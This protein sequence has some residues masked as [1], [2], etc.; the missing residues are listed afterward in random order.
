MLRSYHQH[1]WILI[2]FYI[3][4]YEKILLRDSGRISL[5]EFGHFEWISAGCK[6]RQSLL[7][8]TVYNFPS[9]WLWSLYRVPNSFPE[10]EIWIIGLRRCAVPYHYTHITYGALV[11]LV[12]MLLLGEHGMNS[13][14]PSRNT[15]NAHNVQKQIR[16]T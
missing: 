8:H 13:K 15:F 9:Y 5:H 10:A 11:S 14:R 4:W 3:L 7:F 6:R 12:H 2:N 16:M 1:S